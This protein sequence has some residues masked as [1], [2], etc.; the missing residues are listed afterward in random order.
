[1][2]ALPFRFLPGYLWLTPATSLKKKMGFSIIFCRAL[3]DS[4]WKNMF[5]V[6]V[7]QQLSKTSNCLKVLV[8]IDCSSSKQS[9]YHFYA[10][11]RDVIR[12]NSYVFFLIMFVIRFFDCLEI[13]SILYNSVFF[14]STG[15]LLFFTCNFWFKWQK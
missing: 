4:Y 6:K 1:M 12:C 8:D 9:S 3:S 7:S 14:W 13:L 5:G 2:L 11:V 15:I 10:K